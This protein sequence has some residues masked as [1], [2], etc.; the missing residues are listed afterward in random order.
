MWCPK[1]ERSNARE[2]D[3]PNVWKPNVLFGFWRFLCSNQIWYQTM[4]ACP[5]SERVRILD[6]DCTSLK[7]EPKVQFQTLF[8]KFAWNPNF[9]VQISDKFVQYST[10]NVRKPDVRFSAFL[11]IVRLPNDQAFR[12]CL[13]TGHLCP[14]IG[15]SV[16]SIFTT[17]RPVFGIIGILMQWMPKS[18]RSVQD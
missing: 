3:Q 10:V 14:V 8:S 17:G 11:L 5:K 2:V 16:P 9:C 4:V 6:A 13:I 15:L 1:S 18:G 12:Q 7:S